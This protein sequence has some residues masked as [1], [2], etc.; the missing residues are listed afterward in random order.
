M[1]WIYSVQDVHDINFKV[2]NWSF[3]DHKTQAKQ[4]QTLLCHLKLES[5]IFRRLRT[6]LSNELTQMRQFNFPNE[7]N[8][9]LMKKNV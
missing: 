2:N 1:A 9:M 5:R 3:T 6:F 4:N 7:H 8:I